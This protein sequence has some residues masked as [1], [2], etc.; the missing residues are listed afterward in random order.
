LAARLIHYVGVGYWPGANT[1]RTR[2]GGQTRSR[3]AEWW[4][5][6]RKGIAWPIGAT[7]RGP[8]IIPTNTL[9]T[10]DTRNEGFPRALQ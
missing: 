8:V 6:R 7:A 9:T 2:R 1:D 4:H 5:C 3:M 10:C